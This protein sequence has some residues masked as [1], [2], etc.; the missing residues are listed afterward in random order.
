[1]NMIGIPFKLLKLNYM[2]IK[3]IINIG[4]QLKFKNVWLQIT[5]FQNVDTWF[6][7][8]LYK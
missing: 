3:I 1:M 4:F 5:D 6:K 2:N 7:K 8:V